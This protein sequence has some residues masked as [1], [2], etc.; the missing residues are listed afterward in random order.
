MRSMRTVAFGIVAL[1]LAA[2]STTTPGWT[3]APAPAI[4]PPPSASAGASAS[5]APSASAGASAAPSGS[6]PGSG[7]AVDIAAQGI[8]FDQ[9]K[10]AAPAGQPFQMIFA[11]EDAGIPHNVEIKDAAGTSVFKGDVFNGVETRTY[12]V[13]ALPAGAYSFVCTVHPNMTGTLAAG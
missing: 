11:N 2:C 10:L 8:A 7:T 1:S 9:T 13:P 6:G 5:T 4:T 3:Y 12:D